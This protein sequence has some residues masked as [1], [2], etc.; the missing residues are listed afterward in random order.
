MQ[1]KLIKKEISVTIRALRKYEYHTMPQKW[2]MQ[3]LLVL[4]HMG[5]MQRDKQKYY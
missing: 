2:Y 3:V 1:A 4:S 5:P